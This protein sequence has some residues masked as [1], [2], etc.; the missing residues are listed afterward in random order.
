MELRKLTTE[1]RVE[2]EEEAV[3]VIDDFKAKSKAA[4]VTYKTA[5]KEVKK[6][7]ETYWIVTITEDFTK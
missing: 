3:Q 1:M 4:V 6:T 2:T 7:G 5:Y